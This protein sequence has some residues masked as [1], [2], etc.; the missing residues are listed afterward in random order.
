MSATN[1]INTNEIKPTRR[2][3]EK[4]NAWLTVKTLLSPTI[5]LFIFRALHLCNSISLSFSQMIVWID[6]FDV[7]KSSPH[8]HDDGN[9]I[10]NEQCRRR[11]SCLWSPELVTRPIADRP[12][13]PWL[14]HRSGQ[15]SSRYSLRIPTWWTIYSSRKRLGR[16]RH[17]LDILSIIHVLQ[18][19]IALFLYQLSASSDRIDRNHQQLSTY[20]MQRY[21]FLSAGFLYIGEMLVVAEEAQRIHC[22]ADQFRWL[23]CRETCCSANETTQ[24]VNETWLCASRFSTSTVA[25]QALAYNGDQPWL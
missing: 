3:K 22:S 5:I 15:P 13:D 10:I 6:P 17:L 21:S 24:S 23:L 7:A 4:T 2:E 25:H 18:S 16:R 8:N 20:S 12:V 11:H 19:S 14:A 9:S 1:Q